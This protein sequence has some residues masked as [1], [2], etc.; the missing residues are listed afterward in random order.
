M[1]IK[2]IIVSCFFSS[3]CIAQS[4]TID[5]SKNLNRTFSQTIEPQD[6]KQIILTNKVLLSTVK[7]AV[8]IKKD[9][10][11]TSA[12]N[13]AA[14]NAAAINTASLLGVAAGVCK[15]IEDAIDTLSKE[16]AESKIPD[17]IVKLQDEIS[18]ASKEG[19]CSSDVTNANQLINLT[20]EPININPIEIKPGD[21][22]TITVTRD[23]KNKWTYVFQTE[24]IS[25]SKIYYG[26]SYLFSNCLTQF[27]VYY[28]KADT[29]NTFL[30][31]K[32]NSTTRNVLKNISPTFMY[33]YL[34][35]KNP[36][37]VA[38]F[39][40]TAGFMLDLGNP[41]VMFGP[42]FIIG[43]NV[44]LNLGVAFTQK[45]QLKGQYMEGQRIRDNLDFDQLHNKIWTYD[46]FF[47]IGFHFDNNPFKKQTGNAANK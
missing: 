32:S 10:P 39:G 9:R 34:F 18:K 20:S 21:K 16:N 27:P 45:D 43:D 29:G 25:H 5:L 26:F 28:S 11:V 19:I 24:T 14:I 8:D 3:F 42:S 13:T 17:A 38:K 15:P 12:I 31:T 47:S 23:D 4:L 44:S 2:L 1:K 35:F 46:L 6:L 40:L 30:V 22:I 7:Y 36:D 33:S 41:S 37:A